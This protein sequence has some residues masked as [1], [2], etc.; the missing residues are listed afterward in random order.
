[1]SFKTIALFSNTSWYIYNFRLNTIKELLN[2]NFEVYVIAPKDEYTILLE[3]LGCKYLNI[4]FDSKSLN[5]FAN[6]SVIFKL[7]FYLIKYRIN[8]ILNFTP[9][10]NIYGSFCTRFCYTKSINNISGFGSGLNMN[11]YLNYII[12]KMYKIS[13]HNDTFVFVQNSNDYDF[14]LNS[15]ISN[16]NNTIL[17]PGSGVDINKFV[18]TNLPAFDKNNKFIFLFIGRLLYSKGVSIL[19]DSALKLYKD[20]E[21][22]KVILVG[23]QDF[24][25][26]DVISSDDLSKMSKPFFQFIDHTDNVLELI[27]H[28]HCVIL[29]SFYKEGTPKSLLEGLSVGRPIITTNIPGCKDT[30]TNKN[31]YIVNPNDT[32]SLYQ[33]M[34]TL[35]NLPYS[36]I[37]DMGLRSRELAINTFDE[38]IVINEYM[39]CI[40]KCLTIN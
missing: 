10:C 20:F 9:K 25:N 31:G 23:K 1:M 14:L 17:I 36:E 7:F 3:K 22:F 16:K 15:S 11:K 13:F 30:A 40:N 28:S 21:N 26:P 24:S 6:L 27:S 19:F 37:E 38:R 35:I 33:S 34:K 29:P 2:N 8:I 39:H 5:F 12:I 32:I 4:D 18:F